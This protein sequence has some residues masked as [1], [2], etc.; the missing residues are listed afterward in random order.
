MTLDDTELHNFY[1]RGVT[2][3]VGVKQMEEIN[4][5]FTSNEEIK[6]SLDRFWLFFAS[7]FQESCKLALFC[8]GMTLDGLLK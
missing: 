2:P 8:T 1:F 6:K 5:I 4:F 7:V 3:V